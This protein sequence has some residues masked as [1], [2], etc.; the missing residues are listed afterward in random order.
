MYVS[1]ARLSGAGSLTAVIWA[2]QRA[3]PLIQSGLVNQ[4]GWSPERYEDFLADAWRRLLLA[5]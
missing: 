1:L 4:R 5:G 3:G 2:E